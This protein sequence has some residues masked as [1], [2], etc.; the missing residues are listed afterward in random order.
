MSLFLLIFLQVGHSEREL[1]SLRS[2]CKIQRELDHPNIVRMLDAFET[3]NEVISVAEY[4]PGELFRLFDQYRHEVGGARR[5]PEA[6]VQELAGDLVAALHYL[7]SKRILHRDIKPQNILLNAEGRAKLC[8]FGFARNLGVNT[9]VL[10]SIKGTPLYMA[11]ELIEEKPYDH[12]ADLWSLGCI[13]YELLVGQPPFST[14]SLFQLI[15]KIRYECIQWPA[16]LSAEARSLLSGLLEKDSRRRLSWPDLPHHPWLRAAVRPE[17]L[18]AATEPL[19]RGLTASQE[20]AKEMQ[21]QD[22]AR[23]LPGGSQTL[24]RVAQKHELAKTQLAALGGARQPRREEQ[25]RWA[26]TCG[27]CRKQRCA[28]TNLLFFYF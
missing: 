1:R 8:D 25:R 17:V 9:F 11:P 14:T 2:E 23:L 19:T 7:H 22:K 24:I 4:V 13:L 18:L 27:Q 3:D 20:L 10:T 26:E 6:R 5:L 12:T 15:K 16:H 28:K 21:R